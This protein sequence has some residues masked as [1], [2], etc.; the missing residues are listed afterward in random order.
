MM[1]P[2]FRLSRLLGM[3]KNRAKVKSL[4]FD[5]DIKFLMNEWDGVCSVTGIPF[6]L[7]RPRTGKV[8]PY[9]P[10]I[11]RVTPS[12]GYVKG[13]VRIVCYQLNVAL[14]EF[15]LEQFDSFVQA[16]ISNRGLIN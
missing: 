14:S 5:L 7:E 11:D 2:S 13:N 16:Y 4:P 8:H 9:A 6:S 1:K 12:K 15:G 3:A 10:S